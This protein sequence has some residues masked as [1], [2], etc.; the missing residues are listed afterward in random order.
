ML[1]VDSMCRGNSLFARNK[2]VGNVLRS[3]A[4]TDHYCKSLTYAVVTFWK[5]WH[6]LNFMQ[7]ETEYSCMWS[8]VYLS[9]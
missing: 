3:V 4:W 1:S 9:V 5:I 7:V 2:L 8:A 6:K